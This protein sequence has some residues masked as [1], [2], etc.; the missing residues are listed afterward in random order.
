MF[1][2]FIFPSHSAVGQFER[3]EPGGLAIASAMVGHSMRVMYAS[4][5]M[6]V[7]RLLSDAWELILDPTL[8]SHTDGA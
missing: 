8:L 5:C 6:A 3:F 7:S 4:F 1:I 2:K